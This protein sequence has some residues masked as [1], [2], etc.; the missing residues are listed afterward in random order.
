[1]YYNNNNDLEQKLENYENEE[2]IL[3]KEKNLLENEFNF[4]Y[5]VI[6]KILRFTVL[7][8][9][10]I[11]LIILFFILLKTEK[12]SYYLKKIFIDLRDIL[13]YPLKWFLAPKI[14]NI[15]LSILIFCF[16]LQIYV[17]PN[18]GIAYALY[19]SD[20]LHPTK[21]YRFITSIFLHGGI[22][23]IL[24]NSIALYLFGRKVEKHFHEKIIYIFL[25]SGIIANIISSFINLFITHNTLPSWGA[26]GGIASLI[27]LT[28]LLEP[29]SLNFSF[30]FPIPY[31]LLGW[32]LIY[33]DLI[34]RNLHD[35]IGHYAHL[36]GYFGVLILVLFLERR[37]KE[38]IK[39]GLLIN[40]LMLFLIFILYESG[41][42]TNMNPEVIIN[43]FKVLTKP[44]L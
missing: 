11:I 37:D 8:P 10:R 26:S 4:V 18:F 6:Y 13:Y 24:D 29:F 36:G 43:S 16:L 34:S 41:F 33:Y 14:T 32:S 44:I 31:F 7:L 39:N 2:K 3:V 21:W 15:L 38:K 19:P 42:L 17:L 40:L 27:M 28:I 35:H 30:G 5:N 20:L 25:F 9:I 12:S 1:M 23:H 22:L